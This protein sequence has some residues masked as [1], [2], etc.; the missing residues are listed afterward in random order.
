M[1]DDNLDAMTQEQVDEREAK[2]LAEVA[3]IQA[4]KEKVRK[5]R[6]EGHVNEVRGLVQKYGLSV[7]EVFPDVRLAPVAAPP[8]PAAPKGAPTGAKRGR[9]EG[10]LQGPVSVK[11]RDESGR[12]W[13]GR[14]L[15][16]AWLEAYQAGGGKLLALAVPGLT[17]NGELT[18]D[19]AS[20][21]MRPPK[22]VQM[23]LD[24]GVTPEQLKAG[25]NKPA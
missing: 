14:G 2:A 17:W 13:S 1:V 8:A 7:T 5:A 20:K 12:E 11:F 22:W 15:P 24:E 4:F 16:A 10:D 6:H 23:L 25:L 21:E 3:R 9:K 19:S 18:R